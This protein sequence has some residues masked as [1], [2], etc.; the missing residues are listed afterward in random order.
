MVHVET[1]QQ[2][3]RYWGCKPQPAEFSDGFM[4]ALINITAYRVDCTATLWRPNYL[5]LA[6]G[7]A[8]SAVVQFVGLR[9]WIRYFLPAATCT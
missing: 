1:I 8:A 2:Q 4:R 3:V 9:I 6:V 7:F 5:D